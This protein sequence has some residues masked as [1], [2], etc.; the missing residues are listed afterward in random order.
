MPSVYKFARVSLTVLAI[1]F[2]AVV[3]CQS[4]VKK[5]AAKPAAKPVAK[6][7]PAKPA[8]VVAAKVLTVV[9]GQPFE[10]VPASG[11]SKVSVTLCPEETAAVTFSVRSSKPLKGVKVVPADF[12][13]PT[14]F[15]KTNL[16][17]RMVSSQSLLGCDSVDIGPTPVQLWVNVSAPRD[18]KPAKYSGSVAFL[19]QGK[20]V[21]RVPI[22]AQVLKL[23]LIGSSKQY[24]IYTSLGPGAGGSA[25]MNGT[26]YGRFLTSAAKLGFRAVSVNSDPARA[27]E[28]FAACSSAGLLGTTPV[29][30][31]AVGP[32]AVSLEQMKAVEEVRRSSGL[33][34]L[35]CFCA[36]NPAT[37]AEINTAIER[38][39]LLRQARHQVGVTVS[40]EVATQKMMSYVDGI[41]YRYDMP[42]VQALI[43][44]GTNR[45]N[46]WEWYWWDARESVTKNRIYSGI[47][48][49]KSGLYG[50]MPF[51]MPT[52]GE[53]GSASLDSLLGE[54]MREGI[55]DTRYITTYMKA[56]RELKDKKR[57]PDKEY[58]ESTEAYLAAFLA[59]P[60]DK[61]TP[62]ELRAFRAKMAEFSIKLAAML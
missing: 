20:V 23:R 38:A 37:E 50:C 10:P 40:D 31:F 62:A 47:A 7:A 55:N 52:E 61:Q 58:I 4:A 21:D 32:S 36:N 54:A 30:C 16:S 12:T 6:K 1:A 28:A 22:E 26:D 35:Y 45:T 39:M 44:G 25:E 18:A 49:W 33:R 2:L 15:P 11:A 24:A 59:R 48:L 3:A 5:P 41:N 9:A 8:P 14:K 42:Y 56:L 51:W 53:D 46:K 34:S 29:L 60:F 17:V 13:G 43:G 19:V 27:G 57:E